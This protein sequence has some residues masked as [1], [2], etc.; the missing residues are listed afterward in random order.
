MGVVVFDEI[1]YGIVVVEQFVK[2]FVEYGGIE[3]VV[4]KGVVNKEGV[5]VVEDWFGWLEV[6]VDV[7][8]D[9]W[10]DQFLMVQDVGEQQ[11]VYVVVVVG[12]IDNFMV[13]VC[14][15]VYVFGVMYVD[16][17]V[18]VVSGEVENVVGQVDYFV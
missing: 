7:C 13:V 14:Q 1:F 6:E 16:I 17:L 3:F 9:M 8:C 15:L 18:Q 2:V 12:D 11:I 10:R 5:E 4:F